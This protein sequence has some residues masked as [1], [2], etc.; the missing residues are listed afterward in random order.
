[1][2]PPGRSGRRT[3]RRTARRTVVLALYQS[4]IT[5][6]DAVELLRESAAQEGLEPDPYAVD[7]VSGTAAA[8]PELDGAIGD[9]AED[10]TVGRLAALDRAILRVAVYEVLHRE[11]VPVGAAI[12]EAVEAAK[13]LSTDES[14][15]FVN[16][17]LGRIAR[18]AERPPEA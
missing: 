2:S 15:R 1:M 4:D 16:G 14:G 12:D 10:W 18:G 8:L 9:A 3:A 7:L 17:V 5:G 13:E 6:G 11:D